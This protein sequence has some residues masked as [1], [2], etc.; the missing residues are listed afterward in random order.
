MAGRSSET[1]FSQNTALPARAARVTSS[2][3]VPVGVAT[4]T[5][6]TVDSSASK[7]GATG[8]PSSAPARAAAPASASVTAAS[9]TDGQRQ[10]R[11]AAWI[12]PIRPSPASPTRS[13]STRHTPGSALA[14]I[15]VSAASRSPSTGSYEA[16]SCS[17]L[18]AMSGSTRDS[19]VRNRAQ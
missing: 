19:A 6:S 1:G 2:A 16:S 15:N 8:T 14:A 9:S 12:R 18:T 11:L 10:A 4:T 5:A 7:S 17:M 3:C 13:R